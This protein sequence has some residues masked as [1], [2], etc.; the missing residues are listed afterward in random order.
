[1]T[2]VDNDIAFPKDGLPSHRKDTGIHSTPPP[3][4]ETIT[5]SSVETGAF[6]RGGGTC[7]AAAPGFS[8]HHCNR[9]SHPFLAG[10]ESQARARASI[11]L[12][13]A[14]PGRRTRLST[15]T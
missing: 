14:K 11:D 13:D 6:H 5:R 8:F 9:D 15:H 2:K 12:P 4:E 10:D 7:F 1:M 3:K